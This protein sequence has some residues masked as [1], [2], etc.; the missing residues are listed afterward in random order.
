M[1]AALVVTFSTNEFMIHL[2][3]VLGVIFLQPATQISYISECK[4][5]ARSSEIIT[6]V[7]LQ[8]P[9][10]TI[11]KISFDNLSVHVL[12]DTG[13]S[14]SLVSKSFYNQYKSLLKYRHLSCYVKITTLN[15]D[16]KFIG[17]VDTFKINS[18]LYRHPLFISAFNPSSSFDGLLGFDF[19]RKYNIV[20][21]PDIESCKIN[22]KYILFVTR[23]LH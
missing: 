19:I 23:N 14:V 21:I 11:I 22:Y 20:I 6:N 3:L 18:A 9:N 8:H 13:S 17:C 4:N 2:V 10:L 7:N 5:E 1:N 12:V 15:S 16:V